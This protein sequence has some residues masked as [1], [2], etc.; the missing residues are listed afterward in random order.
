MLH[1]TLLGSGSSGN[2]SLV[3]SAKTKVLFDAGFSYR[4]L[5]QRAAAAGVSLDDLA[6]VFVTHEHTDHVRGLGV[7]A[8][9]TGLPVYLTEDTFDALPRGTGEVAGASFFEAGD[10]LRIGDLD[11]RSFSTS[12][13]AA[14]PVSYTVSHG[15]AKL[16]FATDLGC[17][18]HLVRA[19]LDGC[20]ALVLEAN[21][22]PDMLRQGTYPPQVQQRIRSRIGHL[23]NQ[24][25]SSLLSELLHDSLRTVVL[26]HISENNNAPELARKMAAGA[27]NG[28]QATLHLAGQD[29]PTP[30]FEVRP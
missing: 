13:D 5:C 14:D 28:H 19:R 12:H 18:S 6:A 29:E 3:W 2:A 23:S 10:S 24:A 9:K 30:C 20:N 4:S 27:M 8:R 17:G 16:G 7:L 1:F 15:G 25:M 11:I 21:Y 22:C 26:F